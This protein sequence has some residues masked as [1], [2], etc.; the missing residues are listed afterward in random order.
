[1]SGTVTTPPAN[2]PAVGTPAVPS[3]SVGAAGATATTPPVSSGSVNPPATGAARV[4]TPGVN[5]PS[6]ST[7]GV[8]SRSV[9]APNTANAPAIPNAAGSA[10]AQAKIK[11]DGYTNV[12]G[13]SRNR[14]GSWSGKAMRGSTMVDVGVDARGNVITK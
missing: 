9:S 11:A 8:N 1:G 6:V 13:L 3:R 10:N 12:Q 4:T 5:P 7:P 2:P 14:D